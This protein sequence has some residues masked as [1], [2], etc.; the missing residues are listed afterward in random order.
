MPDV[1]LLSE[2]EKHLVIVEAVTSSGPINH[3]RLEQLQ[4]LTKGSGKL[5]YKINYV[6]AFPSRS[7]FRRFVEEIAWGSSVWIENEP[8]NIVH[9]ERIHSDIK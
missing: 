1:I 2:H 7:V 8:N 3:I 9:F 5:G 4:K 6:T